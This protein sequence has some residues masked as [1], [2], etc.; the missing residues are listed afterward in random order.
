MTDPYLE[1]CMNSTLKISIGLTASY[2]NSCKELTLNISNGLA[3]SQILTW[4]AAWSWLWRFLTG[5]P[6]NSFLPEQLYGADTENVNCFDSFLPE[7][8]HGVDS[9]DLWWFV[10]GQASLFELL[11]FLLD[12]PSESSTIIEFF[13]FVLEFKEKICLPQN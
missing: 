3:F 12:T 4:T 11:Y 1:S 5:C 2:L 10:Q 13:S 6:Y 9:E 7:Q 8:L